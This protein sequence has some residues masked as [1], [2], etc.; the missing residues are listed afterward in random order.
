MK[1]IKKAVLPVAGFGTRFLPATKAIPKEM[2]AIIDKPLIQYAVEEA[3]SVGAEEII[4]ITSHTKGAIENH[5]SS[6]PE[7]EERLR[8]SNKLDLLDKLKPSYM[9]DL[10]FSYV[11]QEEQKGLGHAISLAKDLIGDE[12]F[13][14]ILPDD[15]FISSPSCLQQLARSYNEHGNTTIAV[16]VIDKK[17]IHKYGVID[18]GDN[19]LIN[20]EVNIFNI[21]EKP[22]A[23]DA[24]SD[25]AVC[26]RYIFNPSIFKFIERVKPDSSGE[27]QITDAIQLLLEKENVKAKVYDGKKFDCG[28]KTGYVEATIAM[29]MKDPEISDNIKKI[30]REL[31]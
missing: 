31:I 7:L 15:L 25:I 5:F 24:P 26:G 19:K 27:I 16:N 14:V 13:S 9:E 23:E 8:S 17:N 22:S 28:S 29:G 11:N 21:V 1:K 6:Y 2:L 12:P 20:N 18:P 4:F 30:I 3:V 10:K